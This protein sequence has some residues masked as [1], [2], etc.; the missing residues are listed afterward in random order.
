M[1]GGFEFA[2]F[3]EILVCGELNFPGVLI[4]TQEKPSSGVDYYRACLITLHSN[5]EI[6]Q[7][8]NPARQLK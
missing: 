2:R 8:G 6:F 4:L 7:K 5:F 3:G 1:K